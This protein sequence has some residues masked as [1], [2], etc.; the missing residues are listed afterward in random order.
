MLSER[1]DQWNRHLAKVAGECDDSDPVLTADVS[2]FD[3]QHPPLSCQ[4]S[5]RHNL[6]GT[7]EGRRGWGR[8][9]GGGGGAEDL[10]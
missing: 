9:A 2:V 1:Y 10:V 5:F 7:S 8:G 4:A 3:E 6:T